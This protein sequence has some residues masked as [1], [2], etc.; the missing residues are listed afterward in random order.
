MSN[1]RPTQGT[2]FVVA[3]YNRIPDRNSSLFMGMEVTG[4]H[5]Q[6]EAAQLTPGQVKQLSSGQGSTL[7]HD[8]QRGEDAIKVRVMLAFTVETDDA[9]NP[10]Q[11]FKTV[12]NTVATTLA[13]TN[14]ASKARRPRSRDQ[15]QLTLGPRDRLCLWRRR[16]LTTLKRW[17]QWSRNSTCTA[18][19]ASSSNGRDG[20]D[21]RSTSGK[22]R[23]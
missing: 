17:R 14:M 20:P 12:A 21:R 7:V 8:E 3:A 1:Q 23:R 2:V 6:P 9:V 22:A 11:Q 19:T 18:A 10:L 5:G 16:P 15:A 13:N 4:R